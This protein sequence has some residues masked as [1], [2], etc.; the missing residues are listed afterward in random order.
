MLVALATLGGCGRMNFDPAEGEAL[1]CETLALPAVNAN[2]NSKTMLAPSGGYPP[3]QFAFVDTAPTGVAVDADTGELVAGDSVGEGVVEVTDVGG[4]TVQTPIQIGGSTLFYV[5][6]TSNSVPT[7]EVWKSTDGVTWELAGTLPERRYWGGLVVLDN[8]LLWLAGSDGS[9]PRDEIYASTDGVTWTEVGATPFAATAFGLTM[10]QGRLYAAGGNSNADNVYASDDGLA[11]ALVGHLPMDNHGGS[12]VSTGTEM[13]YAGGHN[14][15]LFD[16][17]LASTDG[18]SWAQIGTLAVPREY[19]TGLRVDGKL[20]LIG[21]QDTVPTP[22]DDVTK[23]GDGTSWAP[24]PKLPVGRAL[25]S[26]V[27]LGGRVWSFG[28]SN[29][30]GVYSIDKSS[31]PWQVESSNFPARQAGLVAR[32]TPQ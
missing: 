21:G 28:G 12:L 13:I 9:N 23:S 24:I 25:G 7:D 18:T 19:H 4:C 15:S 22:L 14:G 6:G 17:V 27:E 31:G 32:F 16:W 26:V 20:W 5:G 1:R 2:L 3:Y 11:W 30:A 29:S 8:R 10:H